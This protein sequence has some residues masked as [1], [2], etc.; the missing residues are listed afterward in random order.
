[1]Q[2]R[3]EGRKARRPFAVTP[4]QRMS[5][6]IWGWVFLLPN[7][8]GFLVFIAF[9]VVVSLGLAFTEWDILTPARFVGLKNFVALLGFR[10]ENGTVVPNDP[11][12]WRSLYNTVFMLAVIPFSMLGSLLLAHALNSRIR[13]RVAY[14]TVFFL[15][16]VCSGVAIC[17]LWKWLYNPDFGMVNTLIAYANDCLGLAIPRPRWLASAAWAK[18]ALMLMVF[19]Q[20]IGGVNML[21]YLAALQ[22]I[23]RHCYEA[24]DIDGAGSFRKFWHITVPLVNHATFFIFVMSVIAGFQGGFMAVYTMTRGGPAGATT[25]VEYYLY[26][27]AYEWFKMGYAS[28]IAW[29]L[30]VVIFGVTFLNWKYGAKR[31]NY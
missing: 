21:I 29:V 19:W 9:P 10:T 12:F 2:R 17:L 30:F 1:M 16:T 23:P 15:P 24:A 4:S 22:G 13:G 18:P 25:T 8:L 6:G 3:S 26:S 5:E 14:R 28:C 27:N 31:V 20:T 7:L 11:M